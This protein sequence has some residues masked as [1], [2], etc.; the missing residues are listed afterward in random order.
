MAYQPGKAAKIPPAAVSSHTSLPSQVG[1][2]VLTMTRRSLSSRP[3]TGRSMATPKSKPSRKK[4]P[5]HKTAIS[6]N[7]TTLSAGTVVSSR[8]M[9]NSPAQYAK[10]MGASGS[11]ETVGSVTSGRPLAV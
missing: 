11:S 10:D 5:I 2:M 1:P 7:Q 8:G 9:I 3:S 6:R 4:K